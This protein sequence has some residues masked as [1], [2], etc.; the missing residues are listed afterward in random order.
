M[1][2][3]VL[4]AFFVISAGAAFSQDIATPDFISKILSHKLPKAAGHQKV[5]AKDKCDQLIA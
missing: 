5:L 1:R 3:S 2:Y 4:V